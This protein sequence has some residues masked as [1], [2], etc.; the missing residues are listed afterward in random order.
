MVVAK[1][2]HDH[3]RTRWSFGCEAAIRDQVDLEERELEKLL[4]DLAEKHAEAL[5]EAMPFLIGNR[6]SGRSAIR[7]SGHFRRVS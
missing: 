2:C 6:I 5:D 4:P 3:P 1:V 7:A